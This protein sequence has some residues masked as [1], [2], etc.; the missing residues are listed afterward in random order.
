MVVGLVVVE[1]VVIDTVSSVGRRGV[2]GIRVGRRGVLLVVVGIIDGVDV[3]VL[4]PGEADS[5][6]TT[7]SGGKGFGS[8]TLLAFVLF[9][10]LLFV[11]MEEDLSSLFIFIIV[12]TVG[13]V[14]F[15][16]KVTSLD[17][18]VHTNN[19]IRECCIVNL[20]VMDSMVY[21][22]GIPMSS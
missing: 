20:V 9:W 2:V 17:T 6:T 18:A 4:G 14:V 10:L 7:S 19:K 12:L 8:R 5:G 13:I 15:P 1:L 11:M 22:F 16:P 21:K 3:L